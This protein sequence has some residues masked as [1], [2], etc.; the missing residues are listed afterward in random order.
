MKSI[1]TCIIAIS[2]FIIGNAQ[3][4]KGTI[5][6]EVKTNMHK[7][8]PAEMQQYVPEFRTSKHLLLFNDSASLYKAAPR[9]DDESTGFGGEG[10]GG[11]TRVFTMGGPGGGGFN[12]GEKFTN[13]NT[14][15][16]YEALEVGAKDFLISDTLKPL[17]WKLGTETKV[18]LG[19]TCH[20]ATAKTIQQQRMMGR[21]SFGGNNN[22]EVKKDTVPP[23]PKEIEIVAWYADKINSG[24]GPESYSGL[25]GVILEL[26][27]DNGANTF[28][29]TNFAQDVKDK[30]LQ[31]PTKGKK[32]TR[33]EFRKLQMDR[34][35]NMGGGNGMIRMGA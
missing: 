33:E 15:L 35:K 34:M 4:T 23:A 21:M 5:T 13:L 24:A 6:Y 30:D 10:G 20:K 7:Y 8:L 29:A 2:A 17:K 32:V 11:G 18:I 3:Q 27:V 19:Y 26:N 31:Q 25:P 14:R 1:F 9:E 12:G 16:T 28:I 22:T